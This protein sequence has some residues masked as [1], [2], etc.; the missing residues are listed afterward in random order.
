MLILAEAGKRVYVYSVLSVQLFPQVQNKKML[1]TDGRG[2]Q[3]CGCPVP[4]FHLAFFSL[5]MRLQRSS[6][7]LLSQPWKSIERHQT[8]DS[9]TQNITATVSKIKCSLPSGV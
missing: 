8:R 5:G 7:A 1:R 9:D 4:H 3:L 2:K 6:S